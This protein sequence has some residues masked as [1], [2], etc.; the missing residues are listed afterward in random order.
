MGQPPDTCF[1]LL[2]EL[3]AGAIALD[4]N[5]VVLRANPAGQELLDGP[6]RDALRETLVK[7]CEHTGRTGRLCEATVA[8]GAIRAVMVKSGD[9]FVAAVERLVTAR[10]R[11]EVQTLR[12]LL[13]AVSHSA[14]T[15]ESLAATLAP[16][17][18]S[19]PRGWAALFEA[20]PSREMLVCMAQAGVPEEH[21]ALLQPQRIDKTSSMAGRA[22]A[23]GV[24]VHLSDLSLSPFEAERQVPDGG[25]CAALALPVGKAGA[26]LGALLLC[27]PRGML[28]EGE[29][30]LAQSLC[31]AAG[32]LLESARQERALR[33]EREARRVLADE[34]SSLRSGSRPG[35]NWDRTPP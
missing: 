33:E 24:P 8:S 23:M 19:L 29:I 12:S 13:A 28:G 20:D 27:G 26:I 7:M 1:E 21:R 4:G 10:L 31:D 15:R 9:I 34:V 3:A 2:E 25:R 32:A 14:P 5:G 6:D 11:A 18:A 16:L 35:F 22:A 30:R 17:A